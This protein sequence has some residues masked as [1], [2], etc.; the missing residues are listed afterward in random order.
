M[1]YTEQDRLEAAEWFIDI[2]DVEDPSP[3][4]LHDWMQ[5]MEESEFH[6]SAFGA[7]ER[8]WRDAAALAPNYGTGIGTT[9]ATET[10][11]AAGGDDDYDG[12]VSVDAWLSRPPKTKVRTRSGRSRWS[13]AWLGIAAA[14]ALGA[15]ALVLAPRLQHWVAQPAA[16][17]TFATRT[18]EQIQVTLPDGSQV[19]L[20]ARSK[21]TVAYTRGARDVRLEAGEAFF[22][23]Q[24]NAARPFRVH[25][26][27]GVVTAVGTAFDVRTTN[28]RV[29]VA[30]AEGVVQVNGAAAAALRHPGAPTPGGREHAASPPVASLRR[31][32]A[33]SF[34]SRPGEHTLE[35]AA[36]TRV[37]PAEPA[38]WRDGWLVYRDEPLRDVLTDIARYTDRDIVV[39]GNLAVNSHFTGAVFKDSII[40][41]LDSLPAAFPVTVTASGSRILIA[42][43]SKAQSGHG[44]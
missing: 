1:N 14:A 6:R 13:G 19:S 17:E 31:G 5:W 44:P 41:W 36:V 15:I 3:D 39:D 38:R 20:G 35:P 23:V 2:H 28:D 10:A 8:A 24:K 9:A 32:E 18:G 40:E 27:D 22:A 16:A 7:V 11:P 42:P 25:V 30:V 4:L 37:D 12:S 21:L 43:A 29:L 26:L 33:I 34:L